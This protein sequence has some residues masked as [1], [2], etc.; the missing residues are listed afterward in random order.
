MKTKTFYVEVVGDRAR[1]EITLRMMYKEVIDELLDRLRLMSVKYP[2]AYL[3][4][5]G[6]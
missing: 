6:I 1:D 2:P 3:Y 4:L 5:N